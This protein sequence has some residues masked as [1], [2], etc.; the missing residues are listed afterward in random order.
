MGS[1]FISGSTQDV[2]ISTGDRVGKTL[3][4]AVRLGARARLLPSPVTSLYLPTS[5]VL[6]LFQFDFPFG[7]WI[8]TW[9]P[10]EFKR[11]MGG[12]QEHIHRL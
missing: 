9:Q 11:V 3:R 2:L 5:V 8:S 6:L 10:C 1:H 4:F 12:E 7:E